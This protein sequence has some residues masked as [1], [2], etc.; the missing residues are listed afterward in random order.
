MNFPFIAAMAKAAAAPP[1]QT[2]QPA[3]PIQPLTPPPAA[4]EAGAPGQQAAGPGAFPA[5]PMSLNTGG[6]GGQVDP[7]AIAAQEQQQQ[8]QQQAADDLKKTQDELQEIKSQQAEAKA[9]VA[10]AELE[11]ETHKQRAQLLQE[12]QKSREQVD[13]ENTK[14]R[15]DLMAEKEKALDHHTKMVERVRKLND[16]PT[17]HSEYAK[18]IAKKVEGLSS[19][20]K[21]AFIATQVIKSAA[22]PPRS[23]TSVSGAAGA[24]STPGAPT[25]SMTIRPVDVPPSN[26]PAP[27]AP[28]V[29][30]AAP[31]APPLNNTAAAPAATP[32]PVAPAPDPNAEL[33]NQRNAVAQEEQAAQPPDLA[34]PQMPVTQPEPTPVAPAPQVADQPPAEPEPFGGG[35]PPGPEGADEPAPLTAAQPPASPMPDPNAELQNQRNAVAQEEQAA[36]PPDMAIPQMDAPPEPPLAPTLPPD[37]ASPAEIAG[38][39]EKPNAPARTTFT[40]TTEPGTEV[41]AAPP[42]SP[43]Q[44]PMSF[45][46]WISQNGKEHGF[47][48]GDGFASGQAEADARAAYNK[49]FPGTAVAASTPEQIAQTDSI[50]AHA[51]DVYTRAAQVPT[52]AAGSTPFQPLG[53]RQAGGGFSIPAPAAPAAVAPAPQYGISPPNRF[54]GR[55]PSTTPSG[56]P[57]TA[58]AQEAAQGKA[59]AHRDASQQTIDNQQ[60]EERLQHYQ[61]DHGT[62]PEG[63][64]DVRATSLLNGPKRPVS[65]VRP[66]WAKDASL[67]MGLVKQAQIQSPLPAVQIKPVIAQPAPAPTPVVQPPAQQVDGNGRPYKPPFV[68]GATDGTGKPY[69]PPFVG[70]PHQPAPAPAAAPQ[71]APQIPQG[72]VNVAAQTPVARQAELQRLYP[73]LKKN[74]PLLY[75]Q[76]LRDKAPV[77]EAYKSLAHRGLV[78]SQRGW[79]AQNEFAESIPGKLHA[80]WTGLVNADPDLYKSRF[81]SDSFVPRALDTGLHFVQDMARNGWKGGEALNKKDYTTAAAHGLRLGGQLATIPAAA[82]GVGALTGGGGA[83]ATTKGVLSATALPFGPDLASS[84]ANAL[85]RFD[86]PNAPALYPS[87]GSG[88]YRVDEGYDSERQLA[89]EAARLKD[90]NARTQKFRGSQGDAQRYQTA[91]YFHPQARGKYEPLM[92]L[93]DPT[94]QAV[95]RNFAPMLYPQVQMPTGTEGQSGGRADDAIRALSQ[96]LPQF[97]NQSPYPNAGMP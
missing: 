40:P 96:L 18:R 51:Q 60:Y 88:Q 41:P 61:Q 27:T 16:Q 67:F 29:P 66:A 56:P 26:D 65:S 63:M 78:S 59:I 24:S 95:A 81:N 52:V 2:I 92:D 94:Y 14:A 90:I 32:A 85:A 57:P 74:K 55:S 80:G 9:E 33:Q 31:A 89:A 13:A 39:A 86:H 5:G 43:A 83:L 38:A 35:H 75:E 28:F 34:T 73:N 45:D 42:T 36:Q 72:Q 82:Y 79:K 70:D 64:A 47:Q 87:R 97:Q 6:A 7:E 17:H 93:K 91:G 37:P 77:S 46:R 20:Q 53:T 76:V 8:A 19:H 69:S 1:T 68:G 50:N 3:Q 22:E 11:T 84:G 62:S 49:Q 15:M 58:R 54:V 10:R 48:Q 23:T 4:G 44:K 30:P 71:P 12:A 21:I 25:P